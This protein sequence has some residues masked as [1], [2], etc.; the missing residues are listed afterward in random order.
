MTFVEIWKKRFGKKNPRFECHLREVRELA[1]ITTQELADHCLVSV[2]TIELIERAKYEPS[3]VL[4][5][6]I[7][8]QLHTTVESLFT[9]HPPIPPLSADSEERLWSKMGRVCLWCFFGLLAISLIGANILFQVPNEENA[10][11]ALFAIWALG[12]IAFLIG[13]SRIP[14]YWRFSRRRNRESTPKRLF[15]FRV[16]GTPILFATTMVI[17]TRSND[18]WQRQ[19]LDFMFYAVFWGGAMYWITFRKVKPKKS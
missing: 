17:T 13:A 9:A 8:S 7:A 18:S 1:G 10:G 16:F 15:W 14:G 6:H 2:E 19:I 11:I 4:A 3:V 5:E 12:A